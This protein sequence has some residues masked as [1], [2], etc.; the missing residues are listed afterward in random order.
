MDGQLQ[1]VRLDAV[2]GRARQAVG[3]S[4]VGFGAPLCFFPPGLGITP[5]AQVAYEL[6]ELGAYDPLLPNAYYT[7]WKALTGEPAGSPSLA[8]YCPVIRTA[9][10]ARLYGVR[11]VLVPAGSAGPRGTRRYGSIGDEDL[12]EVPG[13]AAATL[14]STPVSGASPHASTPSTAVAVHHPDPATWTMVTDS[15]H[16]GVLR[17]RLTDLPGWHATIDGHPV[18]VTDFAGVMLQLKVLAGRHRVELHYWPATF[19][20]GLV[21]AGIAV[22]GLGTACTLETAR[23]RRGRSGSGGDLSEEDRSGASADPMPATVGDP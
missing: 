16:P 14:T 19:T 4:V 18:P 7:S 17:L 22:I 23:R 21:L 11:Y 3:S 20:Q 8:T 9:A 1:T 6:Q 5:N 2:Y 15:A 13:A 10:Q 12:Y